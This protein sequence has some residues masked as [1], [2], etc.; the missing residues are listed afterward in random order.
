[1]K[2]EEYKA[3]PNLYFQSLRITTK[4]MQTLLSLAVELCYFGAKTEIEKNVFENHISNFDM[5]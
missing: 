2:Q 4:L 3:V 1:M 5:L